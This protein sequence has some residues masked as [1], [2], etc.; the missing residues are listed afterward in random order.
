GGIVSSIAN[1]GI[2]SIHAGGTGQKRDSRLRDHDDV[3]AGQSVNA[4]PLVAAV[5]DQRECVRETSRSK[6]HRASRPHLNVSVGIA[7]V[8]EAPVS[9]HGIGVVAV[10]GSQSADGDIASGKT[11]DITGLGTGGRIPAVAELDIGVA[12]ASCESDVT[13]RSHFEFPI[14]HSV[15]IVTTMP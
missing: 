15:R 6:R 14:S 1:L 4:P 2:E 11:P 9:V 10:S 13:P 5:A 12:A 8:R 7:G 3:V